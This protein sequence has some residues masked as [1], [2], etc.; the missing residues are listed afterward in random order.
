MKKTLLIAAAAAMTLSG[1]IASAQSYGYSHYERRGNMDRRL[2]LDRDGRV[3]R[4]EL[5]RIDRNSDGRLSAYEIRNARQDAREARRWAR[6]QRFDHYRDRTYIVTDYSRY[7]HRAPPPGYAY[8]R[9]DTGDLV[10]AAI[11]TGIISSVF[12]DALSDDRR[13]TGDYPRR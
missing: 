7:G 3:E 6:G 4:H 12:M 13:G 5:R 11:A 2:D 8:Y 9:T 1:T 10:L